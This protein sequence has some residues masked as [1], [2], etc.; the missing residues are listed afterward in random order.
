MLKSF[1]VVADND[2]EKEQP[3]ICRNRAVRVDT[4]EATDVFGRRA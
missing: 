2:A 1:P 4:D 3:R